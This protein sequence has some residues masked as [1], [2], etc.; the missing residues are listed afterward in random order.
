MKK[1]LKDLNGEYVTTADGKPQRFT[2]RAALQHGRGGYS[3]GGPRV[4]IDD[5]G[6]YWILRREPS[7][8]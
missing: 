6:P 5:A 3:L 7:K 8:T 4:R 2:K 1:P